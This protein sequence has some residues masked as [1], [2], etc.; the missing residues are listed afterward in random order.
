[1]INMQ[2][3]FTTEHQG[4]V[5]VGRHDAMMMERSVGLETGQEDSRKVLVAGIRND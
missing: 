5:K 4:T 1:M 2:P 3:Y